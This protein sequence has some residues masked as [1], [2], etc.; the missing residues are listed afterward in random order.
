[1][2]TDS[3]ASK[4]TINRAVIE[5]ERAGWLEIQRRGQG[6]TNVYILKYVVHKSTDNGG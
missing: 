4:S 1:M 6:K 5:L 2:A 3:G